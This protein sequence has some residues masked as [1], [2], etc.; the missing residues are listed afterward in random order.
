[1]SRTSLQKYNTVKSRAKE[2]LIRTAHSIDERTI[3]LLENGEPE[4]MV[5]VFD[6]ICCDLGE[7]VEVLAYVSSMGR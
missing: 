3:L 5:K 7:V 6:H 2:M 4:L 1:M